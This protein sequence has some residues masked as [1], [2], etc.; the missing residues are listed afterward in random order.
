MQVH[1][2]HIL[3]NAFMLVHQAYSVE[4]EVDHKA[5]SQEWLRKLSRGEEQLEDLYVEAE[6]TCTD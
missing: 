2:G 5:V 6:R 3:S 4:N 1:S